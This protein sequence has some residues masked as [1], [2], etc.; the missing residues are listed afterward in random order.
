VPARSSPRASTKSRVSISRTSRTCSPGIELP[1]ASRFGAFI[2]AWKSVLDDSQALAD[3]V[4]MILERSV[5]HRI[6]LEILAGDG[7]GTAEGVRLT[8][9]AN[10]SLSTQS[11]TGVSRWST[12][13]K[14][15]T[16][17]RA[18][19]W[20]GEI[21]TI[22]HPTDFQSLVLETAATT[23]SPL[24]ADAKA[25]LEDLGASRIVVSPLA[26]QGTGYTGSWSEFGT[27][28]VREPVTLA[29]SQDHASFFV[30]GLVAIKVETRLAF[31][32]HHTSAA[33]Q[34]LNL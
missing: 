16:T 12:I 8:G 25:A 14:A 22:L 28:Y 4:S 27:V 32:K 34:L 3:A 26:V 1:A 21:V 6:D 29:I 31:R 7:T 24:W 17:I 2:P 33:V 10:Q 18:A 30:Q 5:A 9:L 15:A 19:N 20:A 23:N 11:A 13:V